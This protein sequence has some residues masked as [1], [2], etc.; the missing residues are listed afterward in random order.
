MK[1]GSS[2]TAILLFARSAAVEAHE[3]WLPGGEEIYT[4]LNNRAK[5]LAI[6]SGLP[7]FHITE[8]DQIGV[9]FG[10]RFAHALQE[11]FSKG[12]TSI[13]SIGNDTP[14]LTQNDIQQ[15]VAHLGRH[16]SVIGPSKD[17]GIYLLGIH[18]EDFDFEAFKKLRWCTRHVQTDL[19]NYFDKR[20][21]FVSLLASYIDLDTPSN[22]Q[23]LLSFTS[24]IPIGIII[25]LRA[26][27]RQFDFEFISP[28]LHHSPAL[29]QPHLNKGSPL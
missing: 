13:I 28:Q 26:A 4:Q 14:Q 29:W 21:E 17:G 22:I 10:S 12:Y 1:T 19:T 16:K 25:V 23:Y 11:I 20:A 8:Q 6:D 3:K 9:D 24:F 7:F 5:K 15:A 27:L 2:S 18:V